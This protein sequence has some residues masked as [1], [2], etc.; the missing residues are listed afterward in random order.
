[1]P[2]VHTLK[3][4]KDYPSH[5]IKKGDTYFK[6][7]LKRQYGGVTLKSKTYPR[8]SQLT[9]NAFY[10]PLFQL[11]EGLEDLGDNASAD[12]LQTFA[13]D[14]QSLGEEQREKFDNMPEGLQQGS[15]GETLDERANNC[16]EWASSIE[17]KVSELNDKLE[18][19]DEDKEAE[20]KAAVA[21]WTAY[22]DEY[23]EWEEEDEEDRGEEPDEPEMERPDDEDRDFEAERREAIDE[24]IQEALGENPF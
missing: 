23:A 24:A 7:S 16:E 5:G 11:I 14:I 9:E 13:Q 15:T 17:D 6:W 22:D 18:E 12:D 20:Y 4:A 10:Q 21:A 8:P 3:A 19:L 2:R 1:M